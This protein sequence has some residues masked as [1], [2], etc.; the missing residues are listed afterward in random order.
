MQN[1]NF[2]SQLALLVWSRC[3]ALYAW[4][5]VA[6][7]GTLLAARGWPP[8]YPTLGVVLA[9][10]LTTFSAYVYNDLLDAE[11]D[12][13]NA[14]KGARP[15]ARQQVSER[16]ARWSIRVTGVLG[17]VLLLLVHPMSFLFGSLYY[18]VFMIY[19]WRPVY[20]KKR[21]LLKELSIALAMPL[22][23]LAG[24]YA[25]QT[26][27]H[28]EPFLAFMVLAFYAFTGQPVITDTSDIKEDQ[29]A[30]IYT[31]ASRLQ[32]K[33]K[34]LVLTLGVMVVGVFLYLLYQVFDFNDLLLKIG[35]PFTVLILVALIAFYD[36]MQKYLRLVRR[37][38]NVYY[39]V[40]VIAFITSLWH[41]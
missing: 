26:G 36:T 19:S 11:Q 27:F 37:L 7:C 18:L 4:P 23:G 9:T 35:L 12:R 31:L 39:L 28:A 13:L 41:Q 10:V 22:N 6:L 32:W 21:F 1:R 14:V 3:E 30:G 33:S 38:A 17:I 8:F 15:L 25:V 34:H 2:F 40:L 20:L 16:L 29:L 5:F 24:M